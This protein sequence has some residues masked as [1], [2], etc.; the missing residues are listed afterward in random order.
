[1]AFHFPALAAAKTFRIRPVTLPQQLY[2]S[3][4]I[5]TTTII[6]LLYTILYILVLPIPTAFS[7]TIYYRYYIQSIFF[8]L[9]VRPI[10][11]G[12]VDGVL[13]LTEAKVY[14]K[15]LPTDNVSGLPSL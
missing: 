14:D 10:A 2:T 3:T 11:L 5:T 9:K 4:V 12:C 6:S 15:Q 13:R 8:F 7:Y 1:M